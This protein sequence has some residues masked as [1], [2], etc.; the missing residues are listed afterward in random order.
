MKPKKAVKK[1][2][3]TLGN[4]LTWEIIDVGVLPN[5]NTGDPLRDAMIKINNNFANLFPLVFVV[6]TDASYVWANIHNFQANVVF[7]GNN[8]VVSNG[9]ANA[10]VVTSN[11]NVTVGRSLIANG[12]PG[13]AGQF[14]TSTAGGNV[15]WS[16]SG[17]G[18]VTAVNTG[19]GLTGGQ[20]T[21]TGTISVVAN[22]GIIANTS[23]LFVNPN[24]GIFVN[25]SGV[26]VNT[27]FISNLDANNALFLGGFAANAYQ[28]VNNLPQAV[29]GLQ[30]NNCTFLNKIPGILYLTD[31]EDHTISG[32]YTYTS[33]VVFK[34]SI[35][36]N[37]SP[38]K[39]GQVLTSAPDGNVYWNTISNTIGTVVSVNSGNGLTGGPITATGALSIVA[40]T[41]LSVNSSGLFVNTVYIGTL[42]ANN[43]V[44][45]G[46]KLE[47]AL[48]VNSAAVANNSSFLNGKAEANLNVNSSASSLTSNNTTFVNGK[49]EGN[50]NVNSASSS[51][52]AA[53]LGG[54]A[55]S[56]YVTD[57]A[58]YVI[59][60]LYTFVNDIDLKNSIIANGSVGTTGQLLT[61]ASDGTVYWSSV[62]PGSGTVTSVDSG[63]G[64]TGG[65]ITGTG[66]LSV[67]ANT[68]IVANATGLFVNAAF[69]GTLSANNAAYLNGKVEADLN[70]NSALTATTLRPG[71]GAPIWTAGA[72]DPEGVVTAVVG[73]L[74]TRTDGGA[75]TTLYVKETGTANTGWVAK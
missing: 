15:Y 55:P 26:F 74:Y 16:T 48:N 56:R 37:N 6:N 31:F 11:G 44:Y 2:L 75:G 71:T 29:A 20:I 5:D 65:P 32:V 57:N 50:L 63:N 25:A 66:S 70:V 69:I 22:N 72:G 30:A 39:P 21:N 62:T 3:E 23:G 35:I 54:I 33:N 58:N 43:S 59:S 24:N 64:L 46:G 52:N 51:N 67:R 36:A 38:G 73:S 17:N 1:D 49:T 41:G 34:S 4:D 47:G 19:V 60:G 8:I 18:T 42:P 10:F 53:F 61:S 68:G 28:T 27:A 9:T 14:L 13:I 40:N 45:L 7:S 12:S